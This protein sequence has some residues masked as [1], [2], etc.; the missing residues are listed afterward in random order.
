MTPKKFEPLPA[1]GD[2]VY[3][4]F[5][6]IKGI[7]SS[8]PRPAL[9]L[10]I[11][12]FND[13]T[14]G[15]R[16]AYGTSRK[17]NDLHAGEFAITPADGAAYSHAGLS[18]PTKFDLANQE[19]LPYTSEWFRVPPAHPFGQSPKLGVLHPS[20]VRKAQAAFNAAR[21]PSL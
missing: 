3:G 1:P 14:S 17:A 12:K 18:F 19:D 5:P 11:V 7:P 21:R 2:I 9:V 16:V 8:K 4:L 6:E 20:L 15:I 13:G 10:A